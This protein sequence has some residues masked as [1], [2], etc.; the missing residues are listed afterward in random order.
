MAIVVRCTGCRGASQVGP[1]AAGLLVICPR[2]QEPFLAIEE[3]PVKAAP[4]IAPVRPRRVEP[5][6]P[7]APRRRRHRVA[8][9]LVHNHDAP[10]AH[11]EPLHTTGGL[12][13][14]VLFGFALLPLAIPLLWM[15]G[16]ILLAKPPALTLAAPASL[17]VAAS[18]LC[19]AVVLTVDWTPAT[20]IKGVLI[21][22]GLSYFAGLSLYFLKKDMLDRVKDFFTPEEKWHAFSPPKADFTVNMPVDMKKA[23]PTALQPLPGWTLA[24]YEAVNHP[25]GRPQVHYIV[26]Y[27]PDTRKDSEKWFDEA[28][29]AIGIFAGREANVLPPV[30]V[31][32]L[33]EKPGR[34]WTVELPDDSTRV[35]RVYR[36]NGI[37]YYLSVEGE[38]LDASDPPARL[39]FQSFQVARPLGK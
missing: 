16:P 14:S 25:F 39:F 22:V 32:S 31:Q 36:V 6:A 18:T 33:D 24:C 7:P 30:T 35:I 19:L 11:D 12:P 9:E 23:E 28:E 20:R 34:E 10:Q 26:G 2:C 3:A 5:L 8:A 1:D 38:R 29:K 4:P 17:A 27:G 13:I 15:I 37:V 21:L